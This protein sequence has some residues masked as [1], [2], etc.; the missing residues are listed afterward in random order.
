MPN[1]VHEARKAHRIMKNLVYHI[2]KYGKDSLYI[3]K[4]VMFCQ[5]ITTLNIHIFPR[6]KP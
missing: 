1:I 5:N 6:Q 3:G 4:N 2:N